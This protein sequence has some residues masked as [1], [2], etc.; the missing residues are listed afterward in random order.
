M[1]QNTNPPIA[2]S[3]DRLRT[4]RGTIIYPHVFTKDKVQDRYTSILVV[5]PTT[6]AFAAFRNDVK[7][8]GKKAFNGDFPDGLSWCVRDGNKWMASK[9]KP[10]MGKLAELI[11]D[12]SIIMMHSN[13]MPTVSHVQGGKLVVIEDEL[14]HKGIYTGMEGAAQGVLAAF[15]GKYPSVVFWFSQ[16]AKLGAGEKIGGGDPD[17]TFGGMYDPDDNKVGA[18][19][20]GGADLDD[21][22]P[23]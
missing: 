1:A 6:D 8:F 16:L 7:A 22:I 18:G 23:F 5:D 15:N 3:E 21:D 13:Y 19:Q 12:K 10:P 20:A 11:K 9:G 14:D 4:P 2:K 17:K